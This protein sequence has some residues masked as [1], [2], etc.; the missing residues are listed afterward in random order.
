MNANL[1]L[2]GLF[3][4]AWTQPAKG[5]FLPGRDVFWQPTHHQPCWRHKKNYCLYGSSWL[6]LG[7][8]GLPPSPRR[9]HQTK[10]PPSGPPTWAGTV[11]R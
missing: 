7:H 1:Y 8:I 2:E 6:R 10:L 11:S 3:W 9:P 5:C 4:V